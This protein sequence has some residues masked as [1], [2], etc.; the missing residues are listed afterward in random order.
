MRAGPGATRDNALP[1]PPK[2]HLFERRRGD[3]PLGL[4]PGG[5]EG[6][7]TSDTVSGDRNSV[8]PTD[9]WTEVQRF[10]VFWVRLERPTNGTR[11]MGRRWKGCRGGSSFERPCPRLPGGKQTPVVTRS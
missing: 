2:D 8:G 4:G 3:G 11:D 1:R 9:P 10:G 7:T 6:R 5:C